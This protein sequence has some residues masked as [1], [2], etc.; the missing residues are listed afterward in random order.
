MGFEK[1]EH[2]LP[3]TVL[4]IVD[5]IGLAATEQLVKAIGGARFKF[6]KGKVDTERLAILVEAIGEVKTHELLQVYGGEEL[7]VPRCGKALIQ[8]RNHRFYQ[9]FV[10]L[11]DIDKESGLMAM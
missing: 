9:E 1:V 6:G 3:D 4:D 10:K 2:L 5:V 7:Y 11:R 8:L